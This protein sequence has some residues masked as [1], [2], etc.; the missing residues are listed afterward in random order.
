M[1]SIP[2]IFN[3]EMIRAILDGRKTQ[4]R[5]PIKYQPFKPGRFSIIPAVVGSDLVWPDQ[6]REHRGR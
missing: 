1:K 6:V 3:A 2:I 5:R 4:T